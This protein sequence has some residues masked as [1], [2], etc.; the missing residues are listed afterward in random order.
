MKNIIIVTGASSGLGRE[1]AVQLSRTRNADEIWLLARRKDR[2][3]QTALLIE[4]EGRMKAVTHSI[5]LSGR[6]G[7][8]AFK[9]LLD[10]DIAV[11]ALV[12]NAGFGTYGTFADTP[13]ER[14]LEM[15]DLNVFALT[16]LCGECIPRMK[17]GALIINVASLA[18][19]IP[20]GNFAVYAATKAYVLS[21]S[22]ALSA[23]LKDRGIFVSSLCPGPVD[24]EFA[25][26]ASNGARTKVVD[27]KSPEAVVKSCLRDI[28]RGKRISVMALK[29]KFKAFMSRCVGRY[30]FARYT[31]IH[32]KRPSQ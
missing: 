12:N 16:G 7:V 25:Q 9:K 18:A 23:E 1:F 4:S 10:A 2:L 11:D 24:T 27:G 19:F 20:L 17:P 3:A 32:D 13:L 15:I 28:S 26:V 29:W 5:D 14:E 22:T 30:F 21:F 8:S 6:T 31:Y